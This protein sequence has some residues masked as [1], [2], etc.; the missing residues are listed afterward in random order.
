MRAVGRQWLVG[1]SCAGVVPVTASP[2]CSGHGPPTGA[3]P[4]SL[5]GKR[6]DTVH[7]G[8]PLLVKMGLLATLEPRFVAY[9]VAGQALFATGCVRNRT[10]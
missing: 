5:P 2:R 6:K 9:M 1:G 3:L 7:D 10:A 8:A 4:T